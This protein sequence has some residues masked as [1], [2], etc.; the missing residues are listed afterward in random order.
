VTPRPTRIHQDVTDISSAD[1]LLRY[2]LAGQLERLRRPRE[3][4]SQARI[5]EAAQLGNTR[6]NAAAAL[7][8]ALEPGNR[9]STELL[10]KLDEVIGAVAEDLNRTGGLSALNMRLS[11]DGESRNLRLHASPSWT[12]KLSAPRPSSELDVFAQSSA[13]LSALTA[14]D[15]LD[16]QSVQSLCERYGGQ[17]KDL[18]GRL[19]LISISPPTPSNSDAQT[20][21]ASFAR[22]AFEP[23]RDVL[24]TRVRFHPLAF[25]AWRPITRLVK[26]AGTA[27]SDDVVEWVQ[28]LIADSGRLREESLYP[29]QSLDLELALAVPAALSP[30][31][32]DWA[33]EALRLRALNSRATIRE[34]GAA[35]MGLWQRAIEQGR[36]LADAKHELRELIAELRAEPSSRPDASAGL[37]WIAATLQ[38]AIDNEVAV[39][40]DWPDIGEPWLANVMQA[41]DKLNAY[42]MPSTA[43][44]RTG[45]RNLFL[46]MILQNSGSHRR[47]AIETVRI[48]GM[49]NPVARALGF[50]LET[51]RNEAWLR[52]RAEFALGYLQRVNRHV[53]GDLTN[54]CRDAYDNLHLADLSAEEEPPSARV[55]ELHASL[56]A[57]GDL[58]GVPGAEDRAKSARDGLAPILTAL[59]EATDKRADFVARAARAAAYLLTVTAQPREDTGEQDLSQS[60]LLKL[61]SYPDAVTAR[62]SK[63]ALSFRFAA[64]G[65]VRPLLAA[66]DYGKIKDGPF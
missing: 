17:L 65:G 21:L 61:A 64:D 15:R 43:H 38:H 58:F 40:N 41:A 31:D 45:T 34:R 26:I 60:L 8:H 53:E 47:I 55:T 54:A 35:A 36:N 1:Q 3:D 44:L 48:G 28:Q 19:I 66:A 16:R 50:L 27:A 9:P 33:G 29:G 12:R 2:A 13:L 52:I 5:A 30:P 63:W 7:T 46:Q 6:A 39:C 10:L 57:I 25:R 59:A 4:L 22:H 56:F 51:E 42:V 14:A 62:L 18:A 11:E 37:R 23:M 49:T 32:N 24:D 20:M